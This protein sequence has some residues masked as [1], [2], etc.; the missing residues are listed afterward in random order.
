MSFVDTL[1]GVKRIAQQ[2]QRRPDMV[3]GN[4]SYQNWWMVDPRQEWFTRFIEHR[5]PEVQ[6]GNQRIRFYSVFG[7]RHRISRDHFDGMRIFYTGENLEPIVL[8]QDMQLRKSTLTYWRYRER[9]YGD[10]AVGDVSLSLGFAEK[11]DLRYLQ[12]PEWIPFL[13]S[14]EAGVHEIR[15]QV[16][17]INA[18]HATCRQPGAVLVASH[19]DYG[20]RA[21][22]CQDL[23]GVIPIAY[24][25]R[26]RNNTNVLQEQYGD[27]KAECI[28]QYRFNICPENVDASYYCTEKI[29]DAFSA[30]CIPIYHGSHNDP[31]PQV[32]NK[33]AAILW[34]Y[35][36]DNAAQIAEVQRLTTD[37]AYYDRF[38]AQ[39]KLY[40]ETVDYICDRMD[41]LEQ[42]IREGIE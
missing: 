10:Y 4:I 21:R 34:N 38:M 25:G 35:D 19:D 26:W 23:E 40:P 39:T 12:F 24:A 29:F 28:H 8:H 17:Q 18:A 13:F 31:M 41:Q 6:S 27:N 37:E 33:D 20:T 2:N 36:G 5:I 11:D 30:G 22:I 42:R 3:C 15:E 1:K 16:A 32:I 7:P 14:P 9:N